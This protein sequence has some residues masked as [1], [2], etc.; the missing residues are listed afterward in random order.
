MPRAKRVFAAIALMAGSVLLTVLLVEAAL[1]VVGMEHRYINP[2]HSF[3]VNDPVLGYR[4][5]PNVEAHFTVPG[6]FDVLVKHDAQGFR[7]LEN[8]KLR[9]GECAHNIFV[10]GDSFTWGW[11]V[12]QGEGFTDL[13]QGAHPADCVHNRGVNA[14]GT[15]LQ[16]GLFEEDLPAMRKGD[17]VFVMFCFNDF[18]DNYDQD[19]ETTAII[20]DGTVERI[21]PRKPF[22]SPLRAFL[23]RNSYLYSMGSTLV[24]SVRERMKSKDHVRAK[25]P[26]LADDAPEVVVT[27]FLLSEFKREC[28]EAGAVLK[29]ALVPNSVEY[30]EPD[31][32]IDAEAAKSYRDHLTHILQ[33]HDIPFV[34]LLNFFHAEKAAHPEPLLAITGDGHWNASGHALVARAL[35][36]YLPQG[37]AGIGKSLSPE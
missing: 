2:M 16:L 20:N 13:L 27:D 9:S 26:I 18:K 34:D 33:A 4:G 31:Y 23:K 12:N 14:S 6:Q 36:M 17:T 8:A 19:S 32:G 1:H 22:Q 5:R 3:H 25:R 11:G 29:V 30:G 21:P 28:D 24:G 10:Y 35:T 37:D 7:V 15:A